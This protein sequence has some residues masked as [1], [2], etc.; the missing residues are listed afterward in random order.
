MAGTR[1]V[2]FTD[3]GKLQMITI[4]ELRARL[5]GHFIN[6][7][8]AWD[9][10]RNGIVTPLRLANG[11]IVHS[12]PRDLAPFV[13]YEIFL[14]QCYTAG[15]FYRP[16]ET[17]VVID[18]GANIGMFS[19]FVSN[20]A[21]GITVHCFEPAADT[22]ERLQ[23]NVDAN[24]LNDN[25]TVYPFA[26]SD[27]HRKQELVDGVTTCDRSLLRAHRSLGV[28][29]GSVECITLEDALEYADAEQIDFLKLDVEG[30]ELD[31][32]ESIQAK[33]W[34]RIKR[35]AL[36]FHECIRPGCLPRIVRLLENHNFSTVCEVDP[37][38]AP[39]AGT[40][41]VKATRTM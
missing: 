35:L 16:M 7:P 10:S 33:S 11:L 19:L 34:S 40:G 31:I 39:S 36:E 32:L 13:Y 28:S 12:V 37:E 26:L 24:G 5:Q 18:V 2:S 15:G 6:D 41:I 3:D 21:P 30:A 25:V 4:P 9:D 20:S 8:G 38:D 27:A 1:H 23:H 22:R 17:D 29:V 14:R